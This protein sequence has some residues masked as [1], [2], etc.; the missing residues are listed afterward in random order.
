MQELTSRCTDCGGGGGPRLNVGKWRLKEVF[1][2]GRKT[3]SLSHSRYVCRASVCAD[4]GRLRVEESVA[5]AHRAGLT[6]HRLGDRQRDIGVHV[7]PSDF[8]PEQ[9]NEVLTRCKGLWQEK[10][11]SRLA[12]PEMME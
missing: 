5:T 12:V 9:L 8:T 2:P 11:L 1:P 10:N 7:T 3:C 4:N 6:P